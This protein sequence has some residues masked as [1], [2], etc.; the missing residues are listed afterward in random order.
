MDTYL[1]GYLGQPVRTYFP[2]CT[3]LLNKLWS[4]LSVRDLQ[5]IFNSSVGKFVVLYHNL[6]EN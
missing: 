1:A 4:C 5:M 2:A 3:L 6:S